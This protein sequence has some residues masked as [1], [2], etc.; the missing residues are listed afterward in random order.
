MSGFDVKG[1]DVGDPSPMRPAGP[2]VFARGDKGPPIKL[3]E[4]SVPLTAS[5]SAVGCPGTIQSEQGR[6][7]AAGGGPRARVDLPRHPRALIPK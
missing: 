7:T 5:G 6:Y 3:G 1:A 2:P 4:G